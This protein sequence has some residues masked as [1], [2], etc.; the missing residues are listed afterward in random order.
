MR[1]ISLGDSKRVTIYA[2]HYG[3]GK[4]NLAVNH[5]LRLRERG[6]AVTVMDLDIVNPYFRTKDSEAL[7]KARGIG[8]ISSEFANS[9]LDI[10]GIPAA[11]NSAFDDRSRHFVI[12]LG[13]DDAGGIA[14]GGFAERLFPEE[15]D[16]FMV[17]NR[18]RPMTR[19]PEQA[20][21]MKKD[22]EAVTH[23]KF[24]GIVNNTNLGPETDGELL[25][26]SVGF[27][28]EVSKLLGLPIVF[29]T[30]LRRLY[31]GLEG[32]IENLV[33]ID[34]YGGAARFNL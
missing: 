19:T 12:D 32:K 31:P 20:L 7:F 14:L 8:F 28:E 23:F 15:T 27:A 4:T 18:C 24:T 33:P 25:L 9:N 16:L 6:V 21:E 1:S 22:I 29:T 17:L 30:V 13:G 5:A 26:S 11:V 34:L 10:P 2:G 3:S